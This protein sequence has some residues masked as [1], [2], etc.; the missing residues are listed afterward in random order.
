MQ[1]CLQRPLN[2]VARGFSPACLIT[3]CN[4]HSRSYRQKA[5]KGET[6]SVTGGHGVKALALPASPVHPVELFVFACNLLQQ[7]CNC[8]RPGNPFCMAQ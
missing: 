1:N 7:L 3:L 4:L 5:R 2:P 8:G 6:A